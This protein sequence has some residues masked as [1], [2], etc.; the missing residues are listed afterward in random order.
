M[1]I[2]AID[3]GCEE[4]AYIILDTEKKGI[5]DKH[6]ISNVELLDKIIEDDFEVQLYTLDEVAI[7]TVSSYGMAVGQTVFDTCI[8]TGIYLNILHQRFKNKT[9]LI[10]RQTIKMHH[11]NSVRAKDGEVSQA[12][13]N[14]YGEDST[15]K[16]P[17]PFYQTPNGMWMNGDLWAALALALYIYEP[18]D[19][20]IKNLQEREENKLAKSLLMDSKEDHNKYLFDL[21][22]AKKKK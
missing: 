13:R 21:K 19:Y 17:N 5:L 9:K 3:P 16:N 20:P 15:I 1:R 10:F 2:L 14:K 18:K 11:C 7:E 12:I 6:K 22:E 8:W 4:S